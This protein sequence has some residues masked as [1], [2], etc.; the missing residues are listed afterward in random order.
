MIEEEKHMVPISPVSPRRQTHHRNHS[1]V[2]AS[3]AGALRNKWNDS[4]TLQVKLPDLATAHVNSIAKRCTPNH[5]IETVFGLQRPMPDGSNNT[6]VQNGYA[7][8]VRR[9]NPAINGGSF[10]GEIS[11]LLLKQ[12]TDEV[13]DVLEA[14]ASLSIP[15]LL[16]IIVPIFTVL[17]F[18]Y[19]PVWW[20]IGTVIPIISYTLDI[21]FRCNLINLVNAQVEY[22]RARLRDERTLVNQ[23]LQE[24]YPTKILRRIRAGEQ[25]ILDQY[26]NTSVLFTDIVGFTQWCSNISPYTL[27]IKLNHIYSIFDYLSEKYNV[28]K[29]ETIGDAYMA[30]AG[31]PNRTEDHALRIARFAVSLMGAVEELRLLL[32]KPDLQIRAGI[33]SGAVVAGVLGSKRHQFHLYGDTVNMAARMEST[34][35]P[36]RIQL[37]EATYAE[38]SGSLT[39]VSRGNI[40]IKGKGLHPTYM[41]QLGD[42]INSYDW[43][44]TGLT[45]LECSYMATELLIRACALNT[46]SC[47]VD[48]LTHLTIRIITDYDKRPDALAHAIITMHA[49]HR[50]LVDTDVYQFMSEIEIIVVLLVALCCDL[51]DEQQK[52]ITEYAL[53]ERCSEKVVLISR[54]MNLRNTI[55]INNHKSLVRDLDS[56]ILAILPHVPLGDGD[57]AYVFHELTTDPENRWL[58]LAAMH[59][60]ASIIRYQPVNNEREL[61]VILNGCLDLSRI[62]PHIFR[63]I[64]SSV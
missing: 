5:D 24:I 13:P 15:L 8:R 34:S 54:I 4:V 11:K 7:V 3:T 25:P 29:V 49:L 36:N 43:D 23:L 6:P 32:H 27:A 44:A 62:S 46:L 50:F 47:S 14:R 51:T 40:E 39:C 56:A 12:N 17:G 60:L 1:H 19:N 35:I 31:C 33:H 58:I 28:Y 52:K 30:V 41:L 20:L 59:R 18:L 64:G 21:I 10:T 16:M 26:K 2:T 63:I 22:R 42:W 55:N 53:F 9:K 37:S 61:I 45:P 48:E 57:R 38:L